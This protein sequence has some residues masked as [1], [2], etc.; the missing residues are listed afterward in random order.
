MTKS[1]RMKE[2]ATTKRTIQVD[3]HMCECWSLRIKQVAVMNAVRWLWTIT[4]FQFE[5]V[6]HIK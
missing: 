6:N 3:R 5:Y 4:L 2:D 1:V